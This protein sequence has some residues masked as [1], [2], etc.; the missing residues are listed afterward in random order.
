V[1]GYEGNALVTDVYNF[2]P[3]VWLDRA[4][5]HAG[6]WTLRVE[7]RF[8]LV[9]ADTLRYQATLEDPEDFTRPWTIEVLLY[10]HKEPDKRILEYECHA[11]ADNALGPPE[12]PVVP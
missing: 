6:G 1:G 7:E 9:D 4:G 12:L 10:R 11:Y 5:N 2:H 8:E 3:D